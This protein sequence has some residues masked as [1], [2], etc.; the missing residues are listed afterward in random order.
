MRFILP[1]L[2]LLLAGKMSAADRPNVLFICTDDMRPQLGCY[3][4]KTV[5]SP[6]IDKLAAR[7]MVFKRSYV[8]QALC[9][10]S[11]ISMLSGRYPATTQIFEIGRELRTTMPDIV[12]LPQ[13]F[14]NCG[15]ET[16]SL[17]KIFHS[18]I[19]DEKS[20]STPPRY[21]KVSRY[22]PETDKAVKTFQKDAKKKGITL[23]KT[24]KGSI[25]N[26]VPSYECVNCADDKLIDG[27]TANMAIAQLKVFAAHPEKPFFYGVGFVNPHVPWISPKKYWDL[28]D[29]TEL[30]LPKNDF[31]P[32]NAPSVA[33]KAAN[34]MNAY[35]D[36]PADGVMLDEKK[37]EALHSYYAAISYVDALVGKVMA[38]LEE[39]G[40]AKNTIVVFWS[41]H[42]YYMGEH[43]W[44]ACKHN[45]YEGATR[46]CMIIAT[47]GM[48]MA[49]KK[50]L[51]LAQSVDI[52]PT[53]TELCGLPGEAGFQGR[54]L[55]P[56]LNDAEAEVNEA[57]FS[58]Y[59]SGPWL[60]LAMRTQDWRYVEWTQPGKPTQRELYS[61]L[62]D[63]QNN[64]NVAEKPEHT[65]VLR[66]LSAMLA[67]RFPDRT[68]KKP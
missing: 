27:D 67:S 50:T 48:K 53:L 42:G 40:L 15:Y 61:S 26:V 31:P 6:H 54:S 55:V 34:G 25:M 33:A 7:G 12:T 51:S 11:R 41:D 28:Y 45:N 63:P 38:A 19:D 36:F 23:P 2:L 52:A 65:E 9:S 29:A 22:S 18:G 16:R 60:G 59:P 17:G 10:P 62:K 43:G 46:N 57:A 68:Y 64:N 13:H 32:R 66:Q 39:T 1:T 8:Q 14:K 5:R 58:W 4:D 21:S 30:A 3:G 49:G 44:W 24:G 20:W 56:I 35:S 37:I 47:P